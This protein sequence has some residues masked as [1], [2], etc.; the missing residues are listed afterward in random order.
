MILSVSTPPNHLVVNGLLGIYPSYVWY[1]AGVTFPNRPDLRIAYDQTLSPQYFILLIVPRRYFCCGSN[2]FVFWSRDFV[3]FVHFHI[4][5]SVRVTER[6]PI[7]DELLTRL[8]ICFLGI[9]T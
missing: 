6:P 1:T 5:S 8:T 7:G 9:S 4:S 3:L 2:C